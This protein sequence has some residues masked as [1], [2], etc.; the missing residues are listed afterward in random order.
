MMEAER[1]S[2]SLFCWRCVVAISETDNS[3]QC[4]VEIIILIY[5]VF[6]LVIQLWRVCVAILHAAE[7]TRRRQA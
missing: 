2:I 1:V 3:E 6:K 4:G 7:E 5:E